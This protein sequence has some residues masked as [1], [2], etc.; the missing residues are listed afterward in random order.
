MNTRTVVFSIALSA[1]VFPVSHAMGELVTF[2]NTNPAFSS[3]GLYDPNGGRVILGQSL[4]ITHDA[5]TQPTIG[6]MP[7]GSLM[8]MH[9]RGYAGESIWLGTGR[10]TRTARSEE[11]TLV[12]DPFTGVLV[13]F[14]GPEHFSAGDEIGSGSNFVDGFRPLQLINE[15][16]GD[17]GIF[18]INEL[19]TVGVEFQLDDGVHYGF[20]GFERTVKLKGDQ[21]DIQW[22]PIEWGYET[23][24]GV[25][26]DVIPAPG[27]ISMGM[28]GLFGCSIRRRR[29]STAM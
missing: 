27:M 14:F 29:R 25:G 5:F 21:L 12:P 26:V 6:D 28:A 19:F 8:I 9:I 22:H 2:E 4:D 15:L 17:L 11:S 7:G 24:A 13:P 23:V 20:A 18:T 3:L 10:T 1:F 16:T